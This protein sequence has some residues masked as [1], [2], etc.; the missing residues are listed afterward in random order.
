MELLSRRH[1]NRVQDNIKIAFKAE[2]CKIMDW[3]QCFRI[4]SISDFSATL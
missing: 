3:I 4:G 2:E 1:W